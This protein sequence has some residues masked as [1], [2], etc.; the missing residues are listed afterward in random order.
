MITECRILELLFF[1]Q[2][3][4][5][6][7]LHMPGTVLGNGPGEKKIV[8]PSHHSYNILTFICILKEPTKINESNLFYLM[9]LIKCIVL[10]DK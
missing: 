10:D 3:I 1:I 7:A 8:A 9:A 6:S 4:I 5:L 2:Q